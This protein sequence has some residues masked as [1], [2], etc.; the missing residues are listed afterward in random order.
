MHRKKIILSVSLILAVALYHN[1]ALAGLIGSIVKSF[2]PPLVHLDADPTPE[3]SVSV[4]S[5]GQLRE[6]KKAVITAFN[7]QFI[8]K[9]SAQAHAGHEGE[10]AAH[11]NSRIKLT[12]LDGAVFQK[13]TD[14]A[15]T[16]FTKDLQ[17]IGLEVQPYTEYATQAGYD[18]MKSHFKTS[19]MEVSGGMFSGEPSQ[20]YAPSGMPVV[21]YG[22]E[23][24]FG[25]LTSMGANMGIKSP[26]AVEPEIAK[27]TH[28]AAVHVYMVVDF[29]QMETKGGSWSFSTSVKTKPQISISKVSRCTFVFG[30]TM[31]GGR[32]NVKMKNNA[33]GADGYV[34]EFNDV[35]TSGQRV[36]DAAANVI[37]ALGGVSG[38]YKTT[39]YEAV[40]DPKLYQAACIKYISTVQDLMVGGI[41][42]KMA[43]K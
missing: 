7:V 19:P 29:C 11:V 35:T 1:A 33:F 3:K 28:V 38:S 13:I 39:A 15:Y 10:G 25:A 8:T 42:N 16:N 14:E 34:T 17:S 23:L 5:F 43:S 26:N 41:K 20:V 37:G 40:A 12:G 27:S 32:E 22:D 4:D 18:D 31:Y 6:C 9:K 36:G 2:G 21:V 24:A 30:N